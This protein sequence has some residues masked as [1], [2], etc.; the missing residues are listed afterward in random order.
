MFQSGLNAS[1]QS[2]GKSYGGCSFPRWGA[3]AQTSLTTVSVDTDQNRATGGLTTAFRPTLQFIVH[4]L[5]IFQ[6][7]PIA[8]SRPTNIF[9]VLPDEAQITEV[10]PEDQILVKIECARQR[11]FPRRR[12]RAPVSP[13]CLVHKCTI[14]WGLIVHVFTFFNPLCYAA[15]GG[16]LNA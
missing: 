13:V 16:V 15:V 2:Q 10:Q 14:D 7:L 5:S 3:D 4:R 6:S 12:S 11:N 1:F 9:R 8:R